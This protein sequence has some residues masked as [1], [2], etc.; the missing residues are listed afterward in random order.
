MGPFSFVDGRG[1][2][3]QSSWQFDQHLLSH[4]SSFVR[5]FDNVGKRPS[6]TC[7]NEITKDIHACLEGMCYEH[8][9][10]SQD[11]ELALARNV[12]LQGY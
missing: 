3:G 7:P 9:Q 11:Q 10:I 6:D 5:L 2:K 1:E 12:K 8:H 4:I